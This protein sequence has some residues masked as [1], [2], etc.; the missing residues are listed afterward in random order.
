M[1]FVNERMTKEERAEFA[2]RAI[3]NPGYTA[4]I[5]EPTQWTINRE[6][7]VFLV[8]G[9]QEREESHNYYFLLGWKG[10]LIPVK[11]RE[12]WI[13]GSPRTWEIIFLKTPED[14]IVKRSEIMQ[15][16]KD[17]LTVYG[18]DGDPSWPNNK[19]TK[20]QFNF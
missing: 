5:L 6:E 4:R 12:S 7:N 9:L 11:L 2:A 1:A 16:L 20:V 10:T 18:F 3:P 14:L 17:A 8:W 13:K 15:S 19:T